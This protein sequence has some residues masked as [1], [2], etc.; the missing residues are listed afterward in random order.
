MI[1]T[2]C[3]VIVTQQVGPAIYVLKFYSPEIASTVRPGQFVNIKVSEQFVPLLRRPFSVYHV[4][5]KEVSLI[6]NVTGVGTKI[7]SEK[8]AGEIIDVIGPLGCSFHV[9]DM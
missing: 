5:Q 3:P 4:E 1:Q 9:D 7:L 8:K 2:L 6:F